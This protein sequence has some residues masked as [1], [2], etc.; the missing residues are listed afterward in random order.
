MQEVCACM[1]A[2][3]CVCVSDYSVTWNYYTV[4]ES[5]QCS[6]QYFCLVLQS[7]QTCQ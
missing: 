7:A 6:Y 5:L 2:C 3:V 1:R 4:Q